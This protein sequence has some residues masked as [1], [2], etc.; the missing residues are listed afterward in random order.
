VNIFDALKIVGQKG[1]RVLGGEDAVTEHGR[2]ILR[3]KVT[4]EPVAKPAHVGRFFFF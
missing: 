2:L 4:E 3:E 1:V